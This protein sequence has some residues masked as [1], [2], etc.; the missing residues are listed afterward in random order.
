[1]G[2]LVG[3]TPLPVKLGRKLQGTK[4]AVVLQPVFVLVMLVLVTGCLVD[5]SFNPFLYFRF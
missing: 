3:S 4:A 1:M 2:A 5:G